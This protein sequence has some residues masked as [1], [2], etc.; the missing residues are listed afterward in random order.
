M[1]QKI[2]SGGQTG[3]D[4]AA[5]DAAIKLGITHGGWIPR[6]R[7]T[8]NGPLPPEYQMKEMPTV[9]YP[10]RT[11]MNVIDSDGTLILTHGSLMG[12]SNLTRTYA[13]ENDRP[14]IHIDLVKTSAFK[15][16][17]LIV[18]WLITHGIKV[19][20]VAG[21][22]AGKDPQIYDKTFHIL[23][24]VYYLIL[25]GAT[26]PSSMMANDDRG[27]PAHMLSGQPKTVSEAV[28][29]LTREMP[30]KDKTVLANMSV[31]EL[32]TLNSTLGS[33][34]QDNYDILSGNDELLNSC[35][36]VSG[37]R[38]LSVNQAASVI[39]LELWKNMRKTHKLRVVK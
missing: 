8:E 22:S 24:S 2:I 5:L 30:L 32:S 11:E 1:I 35:R 9:S 17:T 12:G 39:I 28:E 18:E 7:R 25:S 38:S 26:E 15:A 13:M 20:N 6:G 14:Y 37:N 21:S 34:I 23:T 33:Y 10:K 36:F 31:D 27:L 4:R 29:Q 3:A 19:L 16:V